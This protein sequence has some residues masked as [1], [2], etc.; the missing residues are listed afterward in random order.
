MVRTDIH[1]GVSGRTD[2]AVIEGSFD[3]DI[4]NICVGNGGHLSLLNGRNTTF[5]MEDENRDV[6]L[7]SEAIDRCAGC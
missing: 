5:R 2:L 7:V 1:E 6:L 4:V 3:S